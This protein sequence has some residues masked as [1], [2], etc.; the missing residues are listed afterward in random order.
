MTVFSLR[1][2]VA[3][4]VDGLIAVDLPRLPPERRAAAVAFTSR[5][6]DQLPSPLLIGV[7][8]VATVVAGV[9]RIVGPSRLAGFLAR[10]PAPGFGDYVRLLRSLTFAFVWETWP[11]TAPDGAPG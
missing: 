2:S 9:A 8:A 5:R 7:T 1:S 3:P 6:V 4:F 10:H 11:E